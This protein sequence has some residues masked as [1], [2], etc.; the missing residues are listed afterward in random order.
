MGISDE[1]VP[2]L[3]KL[4]MSGVL[5]SLG[6]RLK[7]AGDDELGY[8]EFLY[9]VLVDE[10]E[11]REA[12]QLDQRVRRASFEHQK[13]LEDF[14]FHFNPKL[15][16]PKILELAT[17]AFVDRHESALLIGPAGVGKSH[18]AQAI[19]HR[20]CR[21]GHS[22]LYTPAHE[23]LRQ[24]RAAR[25]D[26]SYERKF[27]RYS[28]VDLL[29]VDDLGLR[30][31]VGDEPMDLYEIIR[32]R[33]QRGSTIVTSNRAVDELGALFGDPLLASA[34]MDRLLH[35]AHVLVLEGDSFRNPPPDRR[36]GRHRPTTPEAMA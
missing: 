26:A 28:E 27:L 9:R 10:V 33:Y 32:L 19:G 36:K 13:T 7:Q 1:I 18:V 12:K 2:L 22:V 35:D 14:D 8:D 24:L 4:R 11:R 34:A 25:A 3:K 15:P 16:K 6:L 20:A 17:C 29:I 21:A 31:L 23:M 5:Q 30:P